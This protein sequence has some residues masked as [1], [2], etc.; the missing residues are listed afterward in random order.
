[1]TRGI[2]VTTEVPST[3]VFDLGGVLID[4]DPRHLYRGL[5]DDEDEMEAFLSTVV[6]PE[7]NREQDRGRAWEAAVEE[8]AAR[9]PEHRPLIEAYH[10]R[11]HEM[12]GGP[13]DG[14]VAILDE[15]RRGGTRVL[16]LSNWSAETFPVA[17][18]RY[19]FLGWFEGIVIS[20]EVRAIKPDPE[21]FV[22]LCERHGVVPADSVFIDDHL[23]NVEA[24]RR[25]GFRAI[26][27]TDPDDLRG[28][29]RALG[30]LGDAA[31]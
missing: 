23:P 3:V 10:R 22:A 11:W 29:L 17:L 21:I 13:I 6:T 4:W 26:T 8:L 30:L 25:L 27:F 7:W 9:H 16:A 5:F 14:S 20:G 2:N 19:P 24:A 15:L 31:S 28:R 18:E 1:V 12:L